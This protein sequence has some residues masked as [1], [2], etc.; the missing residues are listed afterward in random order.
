MIHHHATEA[1]VDLQTV[2]LFNAAGQLVWEKHYNGTAER[3]INV[4]TSN[5]AKGIYV[6]KLVYT[7][8]TIVERLVKN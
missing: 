8:K 5:L 6:L 4:S 1:P 3:L 2:Q 7:N